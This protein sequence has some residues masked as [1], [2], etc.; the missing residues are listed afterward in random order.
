[1]KVSFIIHDRW[2]VDIIPDLL[3]SHV[4]SPTIDCFFKIQSSIRSE[5]SIGSSPAPERIGALGDRRV[6][7]PA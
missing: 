1:M 5:L 7:L 4:A 6:L 2:E 3:I